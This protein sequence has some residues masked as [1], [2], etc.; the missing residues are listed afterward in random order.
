MTEIDYAKQISPFQL[1]TLLT[2]SRIFAVLTFVTQPSG[3]G[4]MFIVYLLTPFLQIG[5]AVIANKLCTSQLRYSPILLDCGTAYKK[6]LLAFY[7]LAVGVIAIF[8]IYRFG[9]FIS[10]SFFAGQHYFWGTL[11]FV[12]VVACACNHGIEGIART[13]PILLLLVAAGLVCLFATSLPQMRLRNMPPIT[14]DLGET[15]TNLALVT[16][17]NTEILLLLLLQPF[18]STKKVKTSALWWWVLIVTALTTATAVWVSAALGNYAQVGG[19]PIYDLAKVAGIP[20]LPKLDAVLMGMWIFLAVIKVAVLL[21]AF[22]Q[23]SAQLFGAPLAVGTVYM[24]SFGL[25]VL[26]QILFTLPKNIATD[27]LSVTSAALLLLGAIILPL[28]G[29]IAQLLKGD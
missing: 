17:A 9:D 26:A 28:T 1:M 13:G 18:T 7:I 19:Y 23:M 10:T 25:W 29:R 21:F 15:L 22:T 24:I 5:I 2:L 14:F 3:L 11:L 27:F 4:S 16:T 12:L 20:V 6:I 8:T